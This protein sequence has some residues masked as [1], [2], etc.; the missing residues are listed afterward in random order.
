MFEANMC[1]SDLSIQKG[2]ALTVCDAGA[3][4]CDITS[5]KAIDTSALPI[6]RELQT[7]LCAF[8]PSRALR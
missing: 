5:Y 3:A 1:L 6:F 7:S 2:D 8:A 4:F